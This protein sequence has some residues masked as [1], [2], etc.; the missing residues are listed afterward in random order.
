MR[1]LANDAPHRCC[2][3]ILAPEDERSKACHLAASL[4]H[5]KG[6]QKLEL[7]LLSTIC[8]RAANSAKAG[9]LLTCNA[10]LCEKLGTAVFGFRSL[11][12]SGYL[13]QNP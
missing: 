10:P 12:F 13:F 3:S 4:H 1:L 7:K 9:V 8:V 6:R 5:I 2:G 11:A